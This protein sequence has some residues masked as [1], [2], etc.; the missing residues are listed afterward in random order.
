[1]LLQMALKNTIITIIII[2]SFRAAPVAYGSSQARGPVRAA[3][4]SLR[5][6]HSNSGYEPRL[7]HSSRQHRILNPVGEARDWTRT[8]MDASRVR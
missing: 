1:M 6:S 4:A 5:Q 7:H 8:L 2:L 3:A